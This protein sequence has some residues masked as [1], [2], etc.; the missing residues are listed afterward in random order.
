M[1]T[2][3]P[4]SPPPDEAVYSALESAKAA[5]RSHAQDNGYQPGT[6][7]LR[8]YQINPFSREETDDEICGDLEN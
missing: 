8:L 5:L 1:G 7:L 2:T 3:A 6:L 4:H